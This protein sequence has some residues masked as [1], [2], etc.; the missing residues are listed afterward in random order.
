MSVVY[1]LFDC[2]HKR[3]DTLKSSLDNRVDKNFVKFHWVNKTFQVYIVVVVKM[4]FILWGYTL[5]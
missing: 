1:H 2:T 3:Y 4:V 5:C